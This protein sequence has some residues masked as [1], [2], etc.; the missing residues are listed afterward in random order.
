[1]LRRASWLGVVIVVLAARAKAA[2]A[3]P[4]AISADATVADV[5]RVAVTIENTSG[6]VLSAV[7]P[8][9]R[10]RLTERRGEPVA[11]APG[12]R[13]LWTVELP[14]PPGPSGVV[15]FVLARW[16]DAAGDQHSQPY[17]RAVETA[18]LLPTEAQLMVQPEPAAGHERAVVQVTNATGDPLHARLVALIPAEFFTTPEAQPVDVPPRQTVAIPIDVQSR[19]PA[20]TTYPLQAILQVTQGGIPRTIVASTLLGIGVT[21]NR[22]V[23]SPLVVGIGALLVA[24]GVL[25]L[26][27]YMARKRRVDA[28]SGPP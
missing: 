16:R 14:P 5:V 22:P 12:E 24:V 1:M 8:E 2:D 6:V 21:P 10:Y 9:V 20:G 18:Q 28:M 15:L 17:A 27:Q 25:V 23:A 19:G 26:A 4:L 7:D 11:L 13:H 3:L